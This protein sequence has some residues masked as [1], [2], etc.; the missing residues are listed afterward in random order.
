MKYWV[1]Q[2]REGLS[3]VVATIMLVLL[4]ITLAVALAG[5][6]V[7]FVTNTLDRGS[8]CVNYR[9]YYKFERDY[10]YNCYF[11]D[12]TTRLYAVSVRAGGSDSETTSA[13][14]G[15][16]LVFGEEGDANSF[17]IADGLP[18]GALRMKDSSAPTLEVPKSGEVL[19]YVY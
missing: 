5:F 14:K 18:I 17:K 13:P 11:Q 2:K 7:P 6:I 8:E 10:G 1:I 9:D 19:T 3:S 12:A 16:K 4:T 15:F